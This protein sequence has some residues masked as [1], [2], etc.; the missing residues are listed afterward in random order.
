YLWPEG[1]GQIVEYTRQFQAYEP[2]ALQFCL[3]SALGLFLLH[4]KWP[5]AFIL[6]GILISATTQ[7]GGLSAG[8]LPNFLVFPAFVMLGSLIGSRFDGVSLSEFTSVLQASLLNVVLALGLAAI[9]AQIVSE[10]LGIPIIDVMIAFVPGGLES[11]A[12]IAI[13]MQADI[14]YVGSHHLFRIIAISFILPI[15]IRWIKNKP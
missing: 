11:M 3:A 5:A 8:G 4:K 9:C 13:T 1:H 12:A 15:L 2:I 14:T 7:L 10:V 6:S